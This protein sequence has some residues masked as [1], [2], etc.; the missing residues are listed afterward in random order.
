MTTYNFLEKKLP[1]GFATE[2]VSAMRELIE[3]GETFTVLGMPGEGVSTFLRFFA[4]QSFAKF[5]F[6]DIYDLVTLSKLE[7]MRQILRNLGATDLPL[8]EQEVMDEIKAKLFE[9]SEGDKKVVIICN[10]FDQMSEKIDRNFLANLYQLSKV[11]P[12]KI[13]FIFTANIP[14]SEL[15]PDAVSGYNLT[16]YSNSYYFG[17]YEA[18]DLKE[19]IKLNFSTV[20]D[21]KKL[22]NSLRLGNGHYQLTGMVLK[23][24][25]HENPLLDKIVR[26]ALSE[27]YESLSQHRKSIV[28]RIAQGKKILEVDPYLNRIGI[29]DEN[30]HLFS[31]L[32][33]EF[34]QSYIAFK[35]PVKERKLFKLLRKNEGEVVTKEEIF[36][37]IWQEQSENAT[38]WALNALVYRLRKNP[39]LKTNGYKVISLKK[40][41]Y[42][43]IKI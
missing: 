27:I 42:S 24:E 3:Q 36:D 34:I 35:L 29:I 9:L 22:D 32:L 14:L 18:K 37:Y 30:H 28:Q 12:K 1:E 7:Y 25:S 23:S 40:Q 15:C 43:L 41:G 16:F 10:R 13:V 2:K 19:M 20:S 6:I 11:A 31:P 4:L 8:D 38:D 5:A 33:S 21:S 39:Q 17:R 26:L